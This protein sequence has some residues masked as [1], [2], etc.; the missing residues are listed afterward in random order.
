MKKVKEFFRYENA[1]LL[2]ILPAFLYMLVFV[3]YPIL[4]NLILS[5]QDVSVKNLVRGA[6][7]FVGFE[8]YLQIFQDEVFV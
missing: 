2:F 3:G 5:L 4:S 6:K 8:N 1:G 7:H